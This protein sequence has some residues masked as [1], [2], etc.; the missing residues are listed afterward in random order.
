M[1]YLIT[2]FEGVLSFISPCMLPMLPL[3]LSYFA[4]RGEG[5]GKTLPRVLAFVMGFSLVFTALGLFAGTL[6]LAL[7]RHQQVVNVVCGALVVV[8][9]LSYLDI[10]PLSFFKGIGTAVKADSVPSAFLFGCVYS[11]SLTP[12]VGAFL[13]SALMLASSSG[14]AMKGGGLLLVYSLGLGIPFLLSAV[15]LEKLGGAFQWIKAR[16]GLINKICGVFL[17]VLGVAMAGG[18]LNRLTNLFIWR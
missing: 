15:L 17:L 14:G 11:I 13:G 4:P 5:K 18:W 2:F 6:G 7:A 16:Y 10:I 1:E 9:G 8:F 3:Y 12:C